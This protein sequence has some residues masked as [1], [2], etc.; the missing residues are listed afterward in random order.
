M[1]ESINILS[2]KDKNNEYNNFSSRFEIYDYIGIKEYISKYTPIIFNQG[3]S[4]MCV[5]CAVALLL[6]IQNYKR[7]GDYMNIPDP[8]YIFGS[9]KI[10]ATNGIS[11]TTA[12]EVLKDGCSYI[13]RNGLNEY[14]TKYNTYTYDQ[15]QEYSKEK[16][17]NKNIDFNY[18]KINSYYYLHNSNEIKF[19]ITNFG[20]VNIIIPVYKSF[21]TI[22]EYENGNCYIQLF[23][24]NIEKLH[25][26]HMLTI[27]GWK[28]KYWIVQS[29]YGSE[30]GDKEGK[31][32]LTMDYPIK[33]AWTCISNNLKHVV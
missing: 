7:V 15:A 2:I 16:R 22:K 3:N 9:S 20:A 27:I 11:Y 5:P 25:S 29:S 23:D 14:N 33:E 32:Y 30:F 17:L 24:D 12:M 10:D 18:F 26:Y 19:A 8:L 1:E 21:F 28:G 6:Y 13:N 31:A 4:K